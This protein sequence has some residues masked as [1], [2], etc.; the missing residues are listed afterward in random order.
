MA[1]FI[2]ELVQRVI[3][4]LFFL[5]VM[6]IVAT[7]FILVRALFRPGRIRSDYAAVIDYWRAPWP[8]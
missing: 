4:W 8:V 3:L 6:L 7:P 1:E 2:I 5:P